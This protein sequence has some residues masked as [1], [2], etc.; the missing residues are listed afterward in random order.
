[1]CALA[2]QLPLSFCDV[3]NIN[4]LS[5]NV[6]NIHVLNINV[7]VFVC[8]NGSCFSSRPHCQ[9][10]DGSAAAPPT[11]ATAAAARKCAPEVGADP[12]RV[13]Q[14]RLYT[15]YMTVYLVMSLPKIPYVYTVY[16]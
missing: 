7:C 2:R 4:V 16:V 8:R 14:N 5:I 6:L 13:G 10:H 11:T 9:W 3:L 15:P 1:V 12:A